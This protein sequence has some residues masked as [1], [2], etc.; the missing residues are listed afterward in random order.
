MPG[1][2]L[3]EGFGKYPYLINWH[4]INYIQY[5]NFRIKDFTEEPTIL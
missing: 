1:R 4:L 5:N 3:N 2:N